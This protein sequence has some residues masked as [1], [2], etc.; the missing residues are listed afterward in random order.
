[1]EILNKQ[2]KKFRENLNLTQSEFAEKLETTQA[3]VSS[4]ESGKSDPSNA[5]IRKLKAIYP[6]LNI[7]WLY[8]GQGKSFKQKNADDE[9]YIDLGSAKVGQNI[10]HDQLVV[11]MQKQIEYLKKNEEYREKNE[12]HLR[13]DIEFYKKMLLG[14]QG[15]QG[16]Q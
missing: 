11:E 12:E 7:D 5:I 6:D 9:R 14:N 16:E 13:K 3:N 2:L 8:S 10:N 15:Q 1:M 4:W